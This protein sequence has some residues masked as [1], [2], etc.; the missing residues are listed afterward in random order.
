MSDAAYPRTFPAGRGRHALSQADR[1][2]CRR[3]AA[4]DG[5][6]VVKVAPEALTLLAR[7]GLCRLPASAAPRPSGAAARD[8]RRPRGLGERPLRRLRSAEERQYRGR[9]GPADVPGHRHRDRHGQE[10]PAGL[11]RRRRRG[12]AVRRASGA[13]TPRPICAT[14]RWRR[15]RC[16]RRSTPATTCRRR[17]TSTPSRATSTNSCSSPRAAARPTRAFCT[18]RRRRC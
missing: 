10:G 15:C 18:S 14:A 16:T 17:S 4:F 2:L 13:P 9:Q 5:E 3:S 11:D 12:G 8:P 6:R 7:A 1:R